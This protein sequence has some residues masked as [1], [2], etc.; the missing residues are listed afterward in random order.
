MP[1]YSPYEKDKF[2]DS[3]SCQSKFKSQINE[4][5]QDF[6]AVRVKKNALKMDRCTVLSQLQT[7]T[8]SRNAVPSKIFDENAPPQENKRN[9]LVAR[10]VEAQ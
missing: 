7:P 9:I 4:T 5:I 6:K 8:E 3:I 1:A 2:D 10:Q